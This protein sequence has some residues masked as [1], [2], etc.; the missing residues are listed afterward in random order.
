MKLQPLVSVI[1]VFSGLL[2][3][4]ALSLAALD[5]VSEYSNAA[6]LPRSLIP[7]FATMPKETAELNEGSDWV[8]PTVDE[9]GKTETAALEWLQNELYNHSTLCL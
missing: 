5:D 2:L 9:S 7:N 3:A 4:P 1:G 8:L 6:E